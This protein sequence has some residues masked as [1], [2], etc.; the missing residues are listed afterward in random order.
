MHSEIVDLS[1][2]IENNMIYYPGDPEPK[3]FKIYYI[4]KKTVVVL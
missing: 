2:L 1:I 3:T 4:G